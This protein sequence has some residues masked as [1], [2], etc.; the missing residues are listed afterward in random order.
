MFIQIKRFLFVSF[1][2]ITIFSLKSFLE[3]NQYLHE[4]LE[5]AALI[6][7]IF[8][9]SYPPELGGASMQSP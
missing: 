3:Y 9:N 7:S 8:F 2:L 5:I 6:I 1:C 4:I